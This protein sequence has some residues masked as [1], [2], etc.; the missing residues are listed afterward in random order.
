M[1]LVIDP[2]ACIDCGVCEPECP[3]GAIVPETTPEGGRWLEM[4]AR[5]A[6]IWPEITVAVEP[7]ETAELLLKEKGKYERYM[8]DILSNDETRRD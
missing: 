5:F 1:M 6:A 4:N 3:A 2:D 8:E 7:L